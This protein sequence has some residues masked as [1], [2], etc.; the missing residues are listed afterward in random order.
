MATWT[1][2]D[3]LAAISRLE[4]E[5]VAANYLPNSVH[6]Y[7][8]YSRRFA[9]WRNGDYRPNGAVGPERQPWIRP[10]TIRELEQDL[11]AYETELRSAGRQPAAVRTYVDH[12]SRFVRW[13]DGRFVVS[14]PR[15]SGRP[16]SEHSS[17]KRHLRP[18]KI[19]ADLTWTWEGTVQARLVSWLE[20]EGWTIERQANTS[21]SEHGID[22][23]ASKNANRLAI[24]VKGYPQATYARGAKAGQAKRW[25]PGAQAR[26]YFG[27]GLHAAIV[28]HDAHPEMQV[29]YALPDVPTY[30]SLLDQVR[31]TLIELRI[32]ALVVRAD[33][34]VFEPFARVSLDCPSSRR[35]RPRSQCLA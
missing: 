30:R 10:A 24:E 25:H 21:S 26:T 34:S 3:L 31:R 14:V 35:G 6:S 29:A 27:T 2:A 32:R 19:A 12:A 20:Q 13:L 17:G 1:H 16:R 8:D 28:A 15:A 11:T 9:R 23:V 22:V 18:I 4:G 33:G 5:L 7:V